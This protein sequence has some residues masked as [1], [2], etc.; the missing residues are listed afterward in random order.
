MIGITLP[1]RVSVLNIANRLAF[2]LNSPLGDIVGY[3]IRFDANYS[4]EHT[5]IKVLTDGMLL[6]EMLI[7]PL[8]TRYSVLM[9]DDCHERSIYTD[10]ILGL[11]KK[12]RRKRPHDLKIIISS[13][14]IE[15]Q[16]FWR[17][18][19]EPPDFK[20]QIVEIEGRQYPVE[21][22]YLE[23]PCKDYVAQAV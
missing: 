11:L 8:L 5:K 6:R 9:I 4:E 2:N 14:T 20:A 15:A 23:K 16:M 19:H 18:F 21:I 12:I 22:L 10:I 17:F 3:Q 1:K 7:D 13:A